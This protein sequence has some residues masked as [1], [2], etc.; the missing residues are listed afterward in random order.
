MNVCCSDADG[1]KNPR[2]LRMAGVEDGMCEVVD[3]DANDPAA[4]LFFNGFQGPGSKT[5][6]DGVV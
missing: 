4:S 3:A 1:F 2:R 5:T 6:A